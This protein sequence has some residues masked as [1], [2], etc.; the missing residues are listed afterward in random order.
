MSL[1]HIIHTLRLIQ[2][3]SDEEKNPGSQP[4]SLG[5]EPENMQG[6][7]HET[8]ELPPPSGGPVTSVGTAGSI[9]YGQERPHRG[10]SSWCRTRSLLYKQIESEF[11]T[12]VT[13]VTPVTPVAGG[14]RARSWVV[15]P[16][17]KFHRGP[18]WVNSP[19]GYR[20]RS[21]GFGPGPPGL[22]SRAQSRSRWAERPRV[23]GGNPGEQVSPGPSVG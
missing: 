16:V 1:R 12:G 22:R 19:R 11:G 3:E 10:P 7:G 6:T 5:S 2:S 13:P 4:V 18:R 15:T 8:C 23:L 17:N 14:L 9:C 20:C 21:R